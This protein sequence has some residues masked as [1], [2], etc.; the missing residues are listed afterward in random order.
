RTAYRNNESEKSLNIYAQILQTDPINYI[1]LHN[2]AKIKLCME[3]FRK[4]LFDIETAIEVNKAYDDIWYLSL[5]AHIGLQNKKEAERDI[6]HI[7]GLDMQKKAFN[8]I[9]EFLNKLEHF[10]VEWFRILVDSCSYNA[11]YNLD[12]SN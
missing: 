8:V 7:R 2:G 12:N 4:A 10:D 9:S 5:V 3:N 11:M 6:R 1:A